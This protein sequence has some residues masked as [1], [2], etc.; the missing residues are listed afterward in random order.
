M[1]ASERPELAGQGERDEEVRHGQQQVSLLL[2]P[3]QRLVVLALG[4]VPVAA[5]MVEVLSLVAVRAMVD[6]STQDRSAAPLNGPH[7]LVVAGRH[8]VAEAGTVLGSVPL[9]DR[10]HLYHARSAM[11]RV[12][13]STAA[14]SEGGVRWR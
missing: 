9:E 8:P 5:G 2:Q 12:I 10:G 7:D 6:V 14:S 4:T 1:A 3:A 13:V 11:S